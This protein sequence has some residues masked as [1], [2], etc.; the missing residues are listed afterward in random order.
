[1]YDWEREFTGDMRIPLIPGDDLPSGGL[2]GPIMNIR[3][4]KL[5]LAIISLLTATAVLVLFSINYRSGSKSMGKR[6]HR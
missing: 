4:R 2:G 3:N 6:R 5:I 1:M